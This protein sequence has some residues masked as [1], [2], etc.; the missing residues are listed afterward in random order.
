MSRAC[1]TRRPP[2]CVTLVART[3]GLVGV[4][5]LTSLLLLH[6]LTRRLPQIEFGPRTYVIG[7]SLAVTYCVTAALV[8][9][10]TP[11]GKFFS[12][13]CGLLYLARPQLGSHL[14]RIMDSPAYQAHFA[15]PP[16]PPP[17]S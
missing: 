2:A 11:A 12:R 16:A 10:G 3:H 1:L 17:R 9:C 7:L 15:R 5:A 14:W 4:A 8:W 6:W 13:L